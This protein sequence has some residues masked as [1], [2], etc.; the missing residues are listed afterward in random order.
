MKVGLGLIVRNEAIDITKCLNSFL[1]QV[2]FCCIIDTGSTDNTIEICEGILKQHNLP[3]HIETFLDASDDQ[4]RI[5]DFSRCR[6]QYVNFIK[7]HTDCDYIFTC[8]ADDTYEYPANLKEYLNS[9]PADLYNIK[10]IL[11]DNG[12][13][14]QSYK[15]WNC[16]INTSIKFVGRVHETLAFTWDIKILEAEIA[17]KHHPGHHDGQEHGTQRNLRILKDEIYPPLRSLFYWAN[18]NVDA[19]NHKE[20]IK[21]YVE[22]I[23]RAREGENV[24]FVE[25][26]HCFFR[27]ARWL[28]HV[29]HTDQA[30][31]LSQEL[32][33]FDPTWS[34]S[35]CELAHIAMQK[36]DITSVRKYALK[37]L[38]NPW[39]LRL[40]SE[41]DKYTTTPANMLMF[42][43]AA[44]KQSKNSSLK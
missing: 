2:D 24:W 34:E 23:R 41:K 37:A 40:F 26:A 29:G 38:E 35:W 1:P 9:N 43:D 21:W 13:M 28:Q 15:I 39:I 11:N 4:K 5:M 22:Y 18:E 3:Y 31:A 17:I 30:I 44:E 12:V 27:A 32:L 25:L 33:A 16:K 36:N 14:I 42:C 7:Y 10:Y 6:N 19:G 8:D 20:A